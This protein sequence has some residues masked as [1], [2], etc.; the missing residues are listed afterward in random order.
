LASDELPVDAE[1]GLADDP[2]VDAGLGPGALTPV[3]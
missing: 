1:M 2:P 3:G